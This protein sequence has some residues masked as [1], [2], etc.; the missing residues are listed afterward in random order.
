M[1]TANGL[2]GAQQDQ[3][4]GKQAYIICET[5]HLYLSSIAA[6]T[7]EPPSFRFL[8]TSYGRVTKR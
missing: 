2:A 8:Y 5:L 4:N 1:L 6:P 3:Y 7:R